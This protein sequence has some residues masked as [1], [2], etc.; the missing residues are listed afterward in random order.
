MLARRI[1]VRLVFA[2]CLAALSPARARA[3]DSPDI[4]AA[5]ALFERNLAAIRAHDRAAY[6]A[7]YRN[8]EDAFVRTG[9][10]GLTV[11]FS[12]FEKQ[13][14]LRFPDTFEATD[15]NLV[16]IGPGSSTG[17]TATACATA[18]TSRAASP[19]GSS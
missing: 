1:A 17:R 14:G 7:C 6:L 8:Q 11:G 10:D 18:T 4:A 16:A 9:D 15:L 19:S 3:A 2:L 12:E 13:A 5:R